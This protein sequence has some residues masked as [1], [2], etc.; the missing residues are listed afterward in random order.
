M[1]AFRDLTGQRFGRLVVVARD[2][3]NTQRATTWNCK[4]DCGVAK[5]IRGAHM[6][7][8]RVVSCGCVGRV[9]MDPRPFDRVPESGRCVVCASMLARASYCM[10]CRFFVCWRHPMHLVD[11]TVGATSHVHEGQP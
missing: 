3:A 5:S 1:T 10:T 4:C 11:M 9:S 7:G 6:T 2:V 8:G